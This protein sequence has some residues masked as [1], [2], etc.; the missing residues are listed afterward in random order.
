[1]FK[2]QTT[3][4]NIR[5]NVTSRY[6]FLYFIDYGAELT[7][8]FYTVLLADVN[9]DFVDAGKMMLVIKDLPISNT[10][11]DST[12]LANAVRCAGAQHKYFEYSDTLQ[13]L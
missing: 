12:K 11:A 7:S 10:L 13:T 3:R 4:D 5:G 1:M 2:L 9:K 8:Q 6:G